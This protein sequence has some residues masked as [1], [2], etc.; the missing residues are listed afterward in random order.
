MKKLSALIIAKA[1]SGRLKNKNTLPFNGEP[2]FLTNVKK[3]L[4][5]FDKVYVSSENED[6]LDWADSRGAITIKRPKELCGLTPNIPV[7]KHAVQF[8]GDIDGIIAVQAN[9]PTIHPLIIKKVKHAMEFCEEVI[10]VHPNGKIYGS[11]WGIERKRLLAYEDFYN[12][13]PVIKI[14]DTSIDIHEEKDY[15]EAL[16]QNQY[17]E[18]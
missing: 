2:M 14:E 9:S 18:H 15:Y 11:V 8:M 7:Y 4:K 13:K 3:C 17:D 6:I 1:D 16:D 12:P 5:I 10:T